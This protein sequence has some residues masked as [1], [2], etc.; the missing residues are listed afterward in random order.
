[1]L[2]FHYVGFRGNIVFRSICSLVYNYMKLLHKLI[3]SPL[4]LNRVAMLHIFTSGSVNLGR[5]TRLFMMKE[6][7]QV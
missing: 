7:R 1:M 4:Y 6:Q 2:I 3:T 5:R